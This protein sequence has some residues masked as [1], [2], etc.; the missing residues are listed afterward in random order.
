MQTEGYAN[1]GLD[2]LKF[3]NVD[4]SFC[5]SDLGMVDEIWAEGNDNSLF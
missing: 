2:P 5:I 4:F 3:F 1:R